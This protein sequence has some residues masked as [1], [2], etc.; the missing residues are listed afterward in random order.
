MAILVVACLGG[1]V[2]L[3][4]LVLLIRVVRLLTRR[5]KCLIRFFLRRIVLTKLRHK[6][7]MVIR[8]V[9]LIFFLMI[10]WF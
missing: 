5:V 10:H 3:R 2:V 8:S 6:F 1:I 9:L 4:R 7:H